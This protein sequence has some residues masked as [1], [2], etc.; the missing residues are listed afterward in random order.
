MDPGSTVDE[1]S[2]K[3]TS[4]ASARGPQKRDN[5]IDLVEGKMT[6]YSSQPI[7]KIII[8]KWAMHIL[9]TDFKRMIHHPDT[10]EQSY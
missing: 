4:T 8:M 6:S 10:A 7:K 3:W 2:E 5:T 1:H 9:E